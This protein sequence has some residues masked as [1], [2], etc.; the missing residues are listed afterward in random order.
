MLNASTTDD[1]VK[2]Y[3]SLLYVVIASCKTQGVP[4]C[5]IWPNDKRLQYGLK[6]IITLIV[7]T[8][9]FYILVK[10][11]LLSTAITA[12]NLNR[13]Y[14]DCLNTAPIRPSIHAPV[15]RAGYS[16]I[17]SCKIWPNHKKWIW[18]LRM[19]YNARELARALALTRITVTT[20]CFIL[21]SSIFS[22]AGWAIH[23][24]WSDVCLR[25]W[26]LG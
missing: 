7:Y 25:V 5:K 15:N 1:V 6:M 2:V 22:S 16:V 18:K 12:N 19:C 26:M 9:Q 17:C 24:S 4:S 20:F 21:P 8:S 14:F 13:G 10:C 23:I 11:V 3:N